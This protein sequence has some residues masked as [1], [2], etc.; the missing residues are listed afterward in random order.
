MERLR[1][2]IVT[3]LVSGSGRM[4]QAEE[5]TLQPEH[6][7]FMTQSLHIQTSFPFCLLQVSSKAVGVDK[8]CPGSSRL[9]F[10]GMKS[11]RILYVGVQGHSIPIF[12]KAAQNPRVK[13]RSTSSDIHSSP[14]G[15]S[16]WRGLGVWQGAL[17]STPTEEETLFFQLVVNRWESGS[18]VAR[19]FH[20][21]R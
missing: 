1:N 8:D 20:F 3:W 5:A 13:A 7:I 19:L 2:Q 21:S 6:L 14:A 12:N 16:G 15:H 10:F 4:W 17:G 11:G 9:E 18:S